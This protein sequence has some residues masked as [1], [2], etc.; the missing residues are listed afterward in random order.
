MKTNR[1]TFILPT[2]TSQ[3]R[4]SDANSSLSAQNRFKGDAAAS[5]A[6]RLDSIQTEVSLCSGWSRASCDL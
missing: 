3:E 2:V 4:I 5:R 6:V 1:V